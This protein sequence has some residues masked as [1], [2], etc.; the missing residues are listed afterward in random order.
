MR[1]A[2]NHTRWRRLLLGL[3]LMAFAESAFARD[4]PFSIACGNSATTCMPTDHLKVIAK[5]SA[6]Q[7]KGVW[8]PGN[9]AFEITDRDDSGRKVPADLTRSQ[10]TGLPAEQLIS[11]QPWFSETSRRSEDTLRILYLKRSPH[12]ALLF[13]VKKNTGRRY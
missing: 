2:H 13:T 6:G 5:D 7:P 3:T 11:L 12:I 10:L 9:I 8:T 4:P 1:S